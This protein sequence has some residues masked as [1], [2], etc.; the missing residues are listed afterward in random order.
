[1]LDPYHPTKLKSIEA[2]LRVLGKR[3]VGTVETA[4]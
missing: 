2:G 4:A 1:M 3:L